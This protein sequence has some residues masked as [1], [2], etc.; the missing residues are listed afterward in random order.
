MAWVSVDVLPR[1]ILIIENARIIP[2]GTSQSSYT[3]ING[4]AT[5]AALVGDRP[6]P[7]GET[8]YVSFSAIL[9]ACSLETYFP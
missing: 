2:H 8:Y 6:Y 9:R 5:A 4:Q 3:A 7:A 1:H